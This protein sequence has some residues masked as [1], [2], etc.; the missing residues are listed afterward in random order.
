MSVSQFV[1][2]PDNPLCENPA[3]GEAS[4]QVRAKAYPGI[5][6]LAVLRDMGSQGV[7]ASVCPAQVVDPSQP[8]FGYRPAMA[9]IVERLKLHFY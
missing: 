1:R 8:N 4:M 9:A 3:T 2:R 5:R 6:H 7:V